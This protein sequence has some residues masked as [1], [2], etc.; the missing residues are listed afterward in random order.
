MYLQ[1]DPFHLPNNR[2]QSLLVAVL[3]CSFIIGYPTFEQHPHFS[4]SDARLPACTLSPPPPCRERP[5]FARLY[6]P[7]Y[8]VSP[9]SLFHHPDYATISTIALPPR[10]LSPTPPQG[11]PVPC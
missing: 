5:Y 6:T 2:F 11:T 7:P 3:L 4:R 1:V 10:R 8:S 9:Y